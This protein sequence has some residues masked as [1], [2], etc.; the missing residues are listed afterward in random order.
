MA[1]A[2]AGP[3][4]LLSSLVGRLDFLV[5]VAALAA[6]KMKKSSHQP[7][8]QLLSGPGLRLEKQQQ[9]QQP[10]PP[11]H[12]SDLISVGACS[13]TRHDVTR[14]RQGGNKRRRER[15][16]KGEGAR[17][18]VG[19]HTRDCRCVRRINTRA[20]VWKKWALAR[21]ESAEQLKSDGARGGLESFVFAAPNLQAQSMI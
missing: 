19:R 11:L 16:S 17:E 1:V 8:D 15:E 7:K 21:A 5:L 10:P 6:R 14:R 13:P 3:L 4:A 20:A 2:L 9:Q 12:L 18:A